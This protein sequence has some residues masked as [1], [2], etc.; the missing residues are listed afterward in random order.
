[1]RGILLT[2]LFAGLCMVTSIQAQDIN[3]IDFKN[4]K[5][6]QVSEQ[7]LQRIW[8]Q[9]QARD[10]S[11]GDLEKLAIARGM[12]PTEV[13]K[14]SQRLRNM[15]TQ[16]ADQQT[17]QA[18]E[19]RERSVTESVDDSQ[20]AAKQKSS[21][22]G[23][24]GASLF[25]DKNLSFTPSLNIPTPKNYELASGDEL[26]VDLWGASNQTYRLMITPEGTVSVENLAPLY[27]SGLTIEEAEERV[28]EH[29]GKVYSGLRPQDPDNKDTYGRVTLGNIR[30]I[31]V[32]ILGEVSNPGT[33]TL[34]SLATV[35][36]ALYMSG[37]PSGLGTYR[38]IQVFRQGK[39]IASLDIYDFLIDGDQEDNIR[40]NDQDIIKIDPYQTRVSIT[41]EVKRTGKFELEAG[42]SLDDLLKMA[43][44]F[45][46]QAYTQRFK[47]YSRT[48]KERKIKDITYP[49]QSDYQFQNG[50]RIHVGQILDRFSNKVEIKGAVYREGEYELSDT[51]SVYS[52]I[53]RADG[54]RGDAF[55]QRALIYRTREDMTVETIPFNVRDVINNPQ[56]HDISLQREDIIQIASIFDLREDYTISINGAVQ[57]PGNIPFMNEMT[58]EDAIFQAN[59]FRESAAPYRIEIARRIS[60]QDSAVV[61]K[62]M[63][64]WYRFEIDPDLELSEPSASFKLQPFDYIYVRSAPGYIEQEEVTISGEVLFPGKYT[65]QSKT[66]RI[67]DLI[68]LAGGFT[69]YAYLQGA[70]LRRLSNGRNRNQARELNV[71][72]SAELQ[73]QLSRPRVDVGIQLNEIMNK[74]GTEQDLL[75]KEGD[76]ITIP[77]KLQTV[78]IAGEVL[79]PVSARYQRSKSMRDYIRRAGGITEKGNLKRAYIVYANGEVDRA[80]NFLLFRNFPKVRPGATIFVPRKEEKQELTTQERIGIL[81]SIVSMAAIVSTTIFQITR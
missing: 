69:E 33:Y 81:S 17:Q 56:Q 31:K 8:S 43:G 75:L 71:E 45:T 12:S 78:E 64:E 72:D 25:R 27:L 24:Y 4:L 21:S 41:G 1:M 36:N 3:A 65:I 50:D 48:G 10:M 59:G 66:M 29:L 32:T 11:V 47:V 77:R 57:D 42:E 23:I 54:L 70:H 53:Q 37:G 14:L 74:P 51:T 52:L 34:S 79:Y 67:S 61:P 73:Q 2:L 30:S 26:I 60:N 6:S 68:E 63:T 58:L 62:K 55:T 49:D 22:N 28:M 39:K 18:M 44:G 5:S 9:A 19:D 40:L 38:D 35:F 7:Q 16:R 20:A 76:Q 15:S 13:S 80:R 46:E